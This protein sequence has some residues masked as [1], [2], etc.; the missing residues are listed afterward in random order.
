MKKIIT[1]VGTSI[2]TNLYAD[3]EIKRLINNLEGKEYVQY[4][5][6]IEDIEGKQ[7]I[8]QSKGLKTLVWEKIKDNERA[9]AEINST[10]KILNTL[11]IDTAEIYLIATDTIL[12]V[13]ACELIQKWFLENHTKKEL[14]VIFQRSA[15]I[16]SK[17]RVD[18]KVNYEDGFMNLINHLNEIISNSNTE[19]VLNITGGYKALIPVLTLYGQIKEIPLYYLYNDSTDSTEHELV[20]IGSLPFQFDAVFAE[21]YYLYLQNTGLL[22]DTENK[23]IR[24]ELKNHKLIRFEKPKNYYSLTPLGSL[25]KS[26]IDQQLAESKQVFGF[27]VEYKIFEKLLEEHY[28]CHDGTI[29]KEIKRSKKDTD[30]CVSIIRKSIY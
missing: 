28:L 1:T 13:L 14:T 15:Q 4:N 5:E 25:Y 19:Y 27:L 21:R 10:L 17:L 22:N 9:S 26:Y 29:L 2:F 30:F 7:G 11:N 18:S 6:Y 8:S 23:N 24:K 3:E 12:S 16:I 20:S